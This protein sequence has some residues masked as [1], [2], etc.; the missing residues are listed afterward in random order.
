M[1]YQEAYAKFDALHYAD[2]SRQAVLDMIE[3]IDQAL[4]TAK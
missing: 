3:D 1:T 2:A 4:Q